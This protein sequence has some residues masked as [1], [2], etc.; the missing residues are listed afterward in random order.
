MPKMNGF[1]FLEIVR[2]ENLAQGSRIIMLTN[3]GLSDDYD[4]ARKYNVDGYIIKTASI[5]AEVYN[6]TIKLIEKPK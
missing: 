6:T 5:P 3:Q 1:Q 2:S 4:N